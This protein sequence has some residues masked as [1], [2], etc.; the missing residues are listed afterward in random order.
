M[1]FRPETGVLYVG[2]GGSNSPY[3]L[4]TVNTTTGVATLVGIT[5]LVSSTG[6]I[7]GL[8]FNCPPP[9][10]PALGTPMRA[11]LSVLLLA[12][13]AAFTTIGRRRMRVDRRIDP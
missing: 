6:G 2:E 8:E 4:F 12:S 13:G 1:D 9:P 11:I 10:T 5:G 7:S 3:G